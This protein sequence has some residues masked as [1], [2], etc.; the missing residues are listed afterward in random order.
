MKKLIYLVAAVAIF[1]SCKKNDNNN[2]P[3]ITMQSLAG[4]Y[5]ITAATVGG[6]DVLSVYLMPCQQ[7]DIYTLNAD[8]TYAITDAG[9]TCSPTSDTTGTWSLTGSQITIGMQQFTLVSF[10]GTTIEA[11]TPITQGGVTVT[12]DVIFTKQ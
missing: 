6:T 4:N 7:D 5:K 11:T 2:P 1:F 10:N 9:T 3:P 12:L 8:S